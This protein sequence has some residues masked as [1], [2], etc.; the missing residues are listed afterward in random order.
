MK[1]KLVSIA[2][3]LL[4]SLT[5]C[6][7]SSNRDAS[8]AGQSQAPASE[9]QAES[10]DKV[11]KIGVSPVPHGEIAEAVKEEVA[12]LGYTLDIVTFDDYVQPNKALDS[13]ELDAN[14]FQHKPYL[15]QFNEENK[16]NNV[17]ITTVH[18]EPLGIY[19]DKYKSLSDLPDGAEIIIPN[20]VTNGARGLLLLEKNG[21]IKLDDPTN[22]NAT[23]ANI[24]ENPKNL[25]FVAMEAPSI[26]NQYK[27][28]DAA[29]INANY[30]LGAGLQ[31]VEDAIAIEDKD[32]PYANIIAVRSGEENSEKAQ[33][34]KKAFQSDKVKTFIE[35][36]YKGAVVPAF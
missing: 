19:S 2:L 15:D 14:Y 29:A 26:P 6:G 30:A 36:K 22:V 35:D 20:D 5:A 31:P 7:S 1:K 24:T 8:Q 18:I 3:A 12:A 21:L 27:S 10:G 33:V 28:A 23:E 32:S 16:L 13:G 4:V 11:I 34:L 17:S 9:S 25:K